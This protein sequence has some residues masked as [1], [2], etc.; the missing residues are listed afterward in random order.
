[1]NPTG[2]VCVSADAFTPPARKFD[3]ATLEKTK[4]RVNLN[5]QYFLTNYALVAA[6][7]ALVIALMHPMMLLFLALVYGLWYFHGFLIRSECI[8]AGI[9]LHSILNIQQRFYILFVITTVVVV[10]QCLVPTLFFASIS[11]V[12][13]LSH[14]LT[15]DPKQIEQSS[16]ELL[17]LKDHFEDDEDEEGGGAPASLSM[18]QSRGD[19]I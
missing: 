15:R 12:L 8:V 18:L 5:I 2:G 7:V 11:S 10:T 4:S 16:N 3:K 6:M 14:A 1:V 17:Y 19:V 13:I 9:H